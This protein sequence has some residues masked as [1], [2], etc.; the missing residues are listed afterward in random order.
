MFLRCSYASI[1]LFLFLKFSLNF[2]QLHITQPPL[3]YFLSD[4]VS[5]S[6]H[7]GVEDIDLVIHA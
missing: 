6:T 4:A 5:T 2:H 3:S 7:G 1:F